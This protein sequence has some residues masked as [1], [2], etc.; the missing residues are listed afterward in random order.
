MGSKDGTVTGDWNVG[1]VTTPSSESSYVEPVY[2]FVDVLS[3]SSGTI[4][5]LTNDRIG[6]EVSES[7][8]KFVGIGDGEYCGIAPIDYIL[9][10]VVISIKIVGLRSELDLVYFH[11]G[12]MGLALPVL[13]ARLSGMTVCVIKIGA[14]AK[15]RI[16]SDSISIL[17]RLLY[18]LQYLSFQ[19]AH[20]A[21][22]FSQSEIESVP[23]SR[24]FIAYSNYRDFDQFDINTPMSE[25][26]VEIGFVGRFSGVK[27]ITKMA[28]AAVSLVK[29]NGNLT[30]RLVGDGPEYEY[31]ESLVAEYDSITLTGWVSHDEI[32]AEYNQMQVMIAPSKGEGL[33][34]GFLEAMGCGVVVI[35][36][37]VGS[38]RDLIEDGETGFLLPEQSSEAIVHK[39]EQIQNRDDLDTIGERARE[40]VTANYSKAAAKRNFAA[41]NKSL[42]DRYL[43]QSSTGM[44]TDE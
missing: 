34:T 24:V 22:V 17:H 30:V 38:I 14:F 21:V 20:S 7:S 3:P 37:P 16:S 42:A 33:P 15:D 12:A 32:A 31:V 1:I 4:V 40:K 6:E 27:G 39:Y 23:N 25:R 2:R 5:I 41:I 9:L 43:K 35:A 10:Q 29:S 26:P 11:K 19:V 36:T 44:K 8:S 28:R 13:V 18:A